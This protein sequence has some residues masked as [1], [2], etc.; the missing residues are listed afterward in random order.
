MKVA[1]DPLSLVPKNIFLTCSIVAGL[2]VLVCLGTAQA[3][4]TTRDTA[5]RINCQ[6]SGA[7]TLGKGDSKSLAR[8]IASFRALVKAASQAADQFEAKQWIQFKDRD[9]QE[10]IYLVAD[11]LAPTLLQNQWQNTKGKT[12]YTARIKTTVGLSDFIRAQ[13]QS[14]ELSA[15]EGNEAYREEMEPDVPPLDHPGQALA[16]ARRLIEKNELRMAIIY[17][18]RLQQNYPNGYEIYET[19]AA[20]MRLENHPEMMFE[21]LR[22]ACELGS[23]KACTLLKQQ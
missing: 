11:Q 13:L 15:A 19:K 23:S 22:K 17:L 3:G 6:T 21:E 7:Y 2:L 4:S 10:L 18:D 20:V 12:F 16:R 8:S 9:K 5:V 1:Q 14:L